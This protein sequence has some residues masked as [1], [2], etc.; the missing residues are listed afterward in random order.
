MLLDRLI[1]LARVDESPQ[2]AQSLDKVAWQYARITEINKDDPYRMRYAELLDIPAEHWP[3]MPAGWSGVACF[4]AWI[5][6]N[7]SAR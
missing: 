4:Q 5:Y 3:Q 2:R 7:A 6:S 1:Q